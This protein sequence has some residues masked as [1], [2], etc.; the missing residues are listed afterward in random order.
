MVSRV[1][2]RRRREGPCC[3]LDGVCPTEAG[4]NL[5]CAGEAVVDVAADAEVPLPLS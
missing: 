2:V 5:R 1:C 3:G 4:L